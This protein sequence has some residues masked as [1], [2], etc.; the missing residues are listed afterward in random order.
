MF[1]HSFPACAVFLLLLLLL[2]S[3]S[4]RGDQP[5]HTNFIPFAR[6]SPQ[7]FSDLRRL[8]RMFSNKLH[9][10]SFPD[11]FPRYVRTAAQSAHSDSVGSRVYA[12]LGGTCHLHFLQNNRGL[13]RAT[14]VTRTSNKSQH[15]KL[16]LETKNS[17]AASAEIRARNLS[18]TSLAL[19]PTSCPGW[20]T[21][22]QVPKHV[23]FCSRL[24]VITTSGRVGQELRCIQCTLG[25]FFFST[26]CTTVQFTL[27]QFNSVH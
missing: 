23:S 6:I 1:D 2:F 16:T 26:F 27:I 25:F 9:V 14:A 19:L 22:Q 17:P 18:I 11:R 15:R 4:Q 5:V 10:S 12:S 7:W 20:P 3:F 13:L 21:R 24:D 8:W